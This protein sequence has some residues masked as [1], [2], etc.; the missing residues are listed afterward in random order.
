MSD[1]WEKKFGCI[2]RE[3]A[4]LA[5]YER[6]FTKK[7]TV[8]WGTKQDPAPTLR[9]IARHGAE[10]HGIAF[11]FEAAKESDV[12]KCLAER[13][14]KDFNPKIVTLKFGDGQIVGGR[15]FFYEG[16]NTIQAKNIDEIA[17]MV[18]YAHGKNG[19][20]FD[21][22]RNTKDTLDQLGLYDEAVETLWTAVVQKQTI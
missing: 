1:G 6:S 4:A 13:E 9:V 17:S 7:S 14:G 19:S 18:L 8:N 2:R 16:K 10:C 3:Q 12:L 5:N 21:Y 15:C 11:E 20:A 22:L